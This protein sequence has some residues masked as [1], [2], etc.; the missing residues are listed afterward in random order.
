MYNCVLACPA[1][2]F[3]IDKNYPNSSFPFLSNPSATFDKIETL[4]LLI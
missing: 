1:E 4:A 3:A 2:A